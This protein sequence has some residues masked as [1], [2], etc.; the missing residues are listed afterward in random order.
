M[1]AALTAGKIYP[2]G[3]EVEGKVEQKEEYTFV[4]RM[5]KQG[6]ELWD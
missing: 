2:E 3:R 1:K 6:L 4:S 5:Q